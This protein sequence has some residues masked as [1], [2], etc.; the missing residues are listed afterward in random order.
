MAVMPDSPE[1]VDMTCV[2]QRVVVYQHEGLPPG[3]SNPQRSA[4][5]FLMPLPWE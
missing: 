3:L 4:V 5:L 1:T 2:E